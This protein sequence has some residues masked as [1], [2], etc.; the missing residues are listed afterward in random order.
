MF[1]GARSGREHIRTRDRRE[2][3]WAAVSA[4][5]L[6]AVVIASLYWLRGMFRGTEA[7]LA[8]VGVLVTA[9]V[10]VIGFGVTRQ[11]NRRLLHESR[12]AEARLRQ[13]REDEQRRLK[14]DAA[15]RAGALFAPSGDQV[16]NPASVA[17][18]LLSLTKLDHADLAVALL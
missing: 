9:T 1:D 17:S 14:L 4:G 15:M 8:F 11:S 16:A 5:V 7:I 3:R 6:I 10:S 13:D 12:Q 2:W 18:G